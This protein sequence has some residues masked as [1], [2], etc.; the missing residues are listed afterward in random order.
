MTI[1]DTHLG[2]MSSA[3]AAHYAGMHL[4]GSELDPDYYNAGCERVEIE[5]RQTTFL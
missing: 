5:T 3:I 1:L 2:S 4:T